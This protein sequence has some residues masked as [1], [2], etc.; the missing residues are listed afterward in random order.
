MQ[1]QTTEDSRG[2]KRSASPGA[3]EPPT[4]SATTAAPVEAPVDP[5]KP[6]E[7]YVYENHWLKKLKPPENK[8]IY[9]S[10]IGKD[11]LAVPDI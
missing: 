6:P 7:G 5:K 10:K 9:V 4:K 11:K 2:V 8:I 1:Q 3:L